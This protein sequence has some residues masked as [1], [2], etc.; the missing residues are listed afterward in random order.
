MIVI[1]II[2]CIEA[3]GFIG[4]LNDKNNLNSSEGKEVQLKKLEGRIDKIDGMIEKN[5]TILNVDLNTLKKEEL[6][7]KENLRSRY[8]TIRMYQRS[9]LEQNKILENKSLNFI[10][11]SDRNQYVSMLQEK[12]YLESV[13]DRLRD[14]DQLSYYVSNDRFTDGN[15]LFLCLKEKEC[16]FITKSN[17]RF[18]TDISMSVSSEGISSAFK[19]SIKDYITAQKVKYVL[20]LVHQTSFYMANFVLDFFSDLKKTLQDLEYGIQIM[21]LESDCDDV[22]FYFE[23]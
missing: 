15:L 19:K 7:L 8:D 18:S 17:E 9:L 4:I 10:G 21:A 5:N 20:I 13:L 23:D 2:F 12:D 3:T 16:H 14:S 11:D 22:V 6:V 1:L